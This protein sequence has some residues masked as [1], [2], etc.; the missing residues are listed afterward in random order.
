MI[1][2][3]VQILASA[4]AEY[5]PFE[6]L[7]ISNAFSDIFYD[8]QRK[9]LLCN[10]GSKINA[11]IGSNSFATQQFQM[12]QHTMLRLEVVVYGM[13]EDNQI[14][15]FVD[16]N[17]VWTQQTSPMISTKC[18]LS[19]F[20][21]IQLKVD[22]VHTGGAGIV[23]FVG[24][25]QEIWGFSDLKLSVQGCPNGCV[26][27]EAEDLSEQCSIWEFGLSNWNNLSG[28]SSEGWSIFNGKDQTS[29]CGNVALIGGYSNFGTQSVLNKTIAMKPH[30]R[31]RVQALWAKIDSWDNE[32]G[33][34]MVDGKVVWQQNY[35]NSDGYKSKICG[36]T[37]EKNYKTVFQRID[38]I[39]D[40]TGNNMVVSFTS[41]LDQ[42][43]E[44][45]SF[46]VRDLNIFYLP[47]ADGCEE[48]QG[49]S[50]S[51]CIK[52]SDNLFYDFGQCQNISNFEMLEQAFT[53]LQF[54][55]LKGWEL[56][57]RQDPI[58]FT[59]CMGAS[60]VGGFRVMGTGGYITKTFQIPPHKNLR[61]QVVIYKIDSW[62]N[63]KFTI[64]VDDAQI[65]THNWFVETNFNYC[66]Q[67]W[68]DSKIYVDLIFE[69]TNEEANIK[70]SSTLNQ[71]AFDESW[72]FREFTLMYEPSISIL[73]IYS[74]TIIPVI[75]PLLVIII[76]L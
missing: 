57:E 63:E 73:E 74:A 24:N 66:G 37:N 15:V 69:H 10:G 26:T 36:N 1:L 27:C 64:E 53:E 45:E 7:N 3:F 59:S 75:Y 18:S 25:T 12:P 28:I 17:L 20:K 23:I 52:C 61:L 71:E 41:T 70:F 67:F 46:G 54:D 55:D 76:Y 30:Y 11:Y 56:H 48:C 22:L 50:I 2:I 40:H 5:M 47:C 34:L 42:A 31:I 43:S 60:L 32:Q 33:Q 49:P 58:Y 72:G 21:M 9:E 13:G 62:D 51:D 4:S 68:P 65:W 19:D 6:A 38:V 8:G 35:T 16:W 44:D 39:V 29:V 14:G